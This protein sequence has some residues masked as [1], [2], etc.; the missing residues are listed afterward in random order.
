MGL[1]CFLLFQFLLQNDGYDIA[2]QMMYTVVG[3]I[4]PNEMIFDERI[5]FELEILF[6]MPMIFD[7][8][9]SLGTFMLSPIL[10]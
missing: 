2:H 4:C 7:G 3:E 9:V 5:E 10:T 6:A 1:I 8:L